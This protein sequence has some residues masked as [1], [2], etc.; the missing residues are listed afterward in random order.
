MPYLGNMKLFRELP[1]NLLTENQYHP[2]HYARGLLC[3]LR[4]YT[5]G[6]TG[7]IAGSLAASM[8]GSHTV[9]C[10]LARVVDTVFGVN[11]F[12]LKFLAKSEKFRRLAQPTGSAPVADS[13][14]VS[15]LGG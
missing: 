11:Y 7:E 12:V 13:K 9:L 1:F 2:R 8:V 14:A 4:P 6:K 10:C 3:I 15:H 5:P